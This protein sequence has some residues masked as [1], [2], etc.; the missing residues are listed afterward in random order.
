MI[1][2]VEAFCDVGIQNVFLQM[3]DSVEDCFDGIMT[4]PPRSESITVWFK[5]GFPLWFECKFD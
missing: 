2:P 1:Y 4:G 5:L 3:N